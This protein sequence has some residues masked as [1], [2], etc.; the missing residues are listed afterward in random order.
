MDD[1]TEDAKFNLRIPKDLYRW[2]K[3]FAKAQ[4][5]SVNAQIVALLE[6]ERQRQAKPLE[7]PSPP[8]DDDQ[9]SSA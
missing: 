2:L 7:P 5:R 1:V 8:A 9:V 3:L 6:A 4:H